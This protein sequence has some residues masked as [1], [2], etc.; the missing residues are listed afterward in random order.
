MRTVNEVSRL[1]GVSVRTLHYYDSIGLLRPTNVTESGYRLYDDAALEKLQQILLYR[2]LEV[3]L[4]EIK[5]ILNSNSFQREKA[6]EEQI[7]LLILKKEHLENL[8]D[9]AR[10]MKRTGVSNM[11]FKV[12]DTSKIDEYAEKAKAQWGKTEAYKEFEQKSKNWS[13]EDAAATGKDLMSIFCEFGKV[14]HKDPADTEVQNLVKKLQGFITE[15]YYTCTK[16][17]LSGLGSMYASGGEFTENI[18][19]TAGKGTAEFAAKAIEI[20]CVQK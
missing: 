15:Q 19:K 5:K 20:F 10:E 9:F 4:K 1:T 14:I 18:N 2:E 8:I 11:D 16:E 13:K 17:I 12:F 3:P 7:E 6:L